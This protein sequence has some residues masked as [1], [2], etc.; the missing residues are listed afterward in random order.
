[1]GKM[2]IKVFAISMSLLL[3]ICVIPAS[4]MMENEN[5]LDISE[6]DD[7]HVKLIISLHDTVNFFTSSI[8]YR[9]YTMP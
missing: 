3:I 5:L 7:Q 2:P 6:L 9:W 8:D 1:M 4:G